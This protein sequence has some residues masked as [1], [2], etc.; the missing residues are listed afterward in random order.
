MA[1]TRPGCHI[2]VADNVYGNTRSFCD[3]LLTQHGVEIEYFDP[4]IGGAIDALFRPETSAIMF[5]SPGSG[6]L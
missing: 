1:L 2:L 6:H 5:E 3:G 4:M